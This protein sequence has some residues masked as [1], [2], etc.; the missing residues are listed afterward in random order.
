MLRRF[1]LYR[2]GQQWEQTVPY[3]MLL[4]FLTLIYFSRMYSNAILAARGFPHL[5]LIPDFAALLF[6]LV[7]M[8]ALQLSGEMTLGLAAAVW[9]LRYLVSVPLDVR[10]IRNVLQ[11]NFIQQINGMLVPL[12]GV[13]VMA[14]TLIFMKMLL[15]Q[16][17]AP[18]PRIIIMSVVGAVAYALTFW[19]L[20]KARITE[21]WHF[22]LIALKRQPQEA[23]QE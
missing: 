1:Y 22:G 11:I 9:A 21:M 16:E 23:K 10:N 17:I 6:V 3:I 19:S 8:T 4:C 15:L 5:P 14:V 13:A 12:A 18:I 20:D 7:C 2:F